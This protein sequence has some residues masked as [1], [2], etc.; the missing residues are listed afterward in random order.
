LGRNREEKPEYLHKNFDADEGVQHFSP[1][2]EIK[3]DD[4]DVHISN[5][6][7]D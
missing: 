3:F 7:N 4:D 2:K 6:L 1:L 5:L